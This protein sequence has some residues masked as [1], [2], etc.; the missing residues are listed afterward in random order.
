MEENVEGRLINNQKIIELE[1][2][3]AG[4]SPKFAYSRKAWK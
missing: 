3:N 1:I 4:Q 2:K